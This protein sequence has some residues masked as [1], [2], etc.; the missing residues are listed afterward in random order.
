M[1]YLKP[2]V[3][4]CKTTFH[5]KLAMGPTGFRFLSLKI[6]SGKRKSSFLSNLGSVS[7]VDNIDPMHH[8]MFPWFLVLSSTSSSLCQKS[9][10]PLH[11]PEWKSRP[12]LWYHVSPLRN[13]Y[14]SSAKLLLFWISLCL[15]TV[16][17]HWNQGRRGWRGPSSHHRFRSPKRVSL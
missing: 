12:I 14:K 15:T 7:C 13:I 17:T 6:R 9:P 11:F 5:E 3:C 16:R 2:L 10:R 8:V 4:A 1:L